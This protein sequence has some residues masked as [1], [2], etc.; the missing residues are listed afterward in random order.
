MKEMISPLIRNDSIFIYP[1][2]FVYMDHPTT[3]PR[4]EKTTN[5]QMAIGLY[6]GLKEIN[7]KIGIKNQY[8]F[9]SPQYMLTIGELHIRKK[10]G[11]TIKIKV[12]DG[13]PI[14]IKV[15]KR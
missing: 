8:V 9:D 10:S 11:E 4:R 1:R 2:R 3:G 5:L 15:L 7:S 13:Y 6:Y 14:T 12:P